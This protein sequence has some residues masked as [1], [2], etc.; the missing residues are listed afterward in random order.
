[1]EAWAREYPVEIVQT[2]SVQELRERLDEV[3]LIDVRQ[4]SEW[5]AGHI[6]GA[7]HF[8]GGRV[9]WEQPP[10]KQDKPVV[11]Q[12]ASGNRSMVAISV[13]QRRGFD[14]LIQLEGGINQW[15]KSGFEITRDS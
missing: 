12:C 15:K 8:E 13:L 10:F 2:M 1:M 3:D 14:N 11:I 7:V 9:A 4:R 5:D 6:P